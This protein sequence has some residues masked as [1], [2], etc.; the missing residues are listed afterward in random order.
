MSV[1]LNE[2]LEPAL[3]VGS[4]VGQF[5]PV[6]IGTLIAATRPPFDLYL[7]HGLRAQHVLFSERSAPLTVEA[8]ARLADSGVQALYISY[9]DRDAYDR[10]LHDALLENEELTLAQRYRLTIAAS[11]TVFEAAYTQ[12][13]LGAVVQVVEQVGGHISQRLL[14][15]D[16]V[17]NQLFDLMF[18]D[19]ST[20]THANNVCIY[21]V[22]LARA[23]GISNLNELAAIATGALLHDIGKRSIPP[24]ILNQAHHLTDA[25]KRIVR[26]H[27][28]LGYEDL[29]HEERLSWGQLM[30]VY[31]HHERLNGSGYPVRIHGDE[32]HPWAKLC[33]VADVFDALTSDRPFR[34]ALRVEEALRHLRAREG[35]EFDSEIVECLIALMMSTT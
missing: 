2:V 8:L 33:A 34:R 6:A 14:S 19:Y 32:M 24:L 26:R 29:C 12:N 30:M 15:Q 10:Y 3:R 20:F 31:Q 4:R 23:T 13:D 21:S 11:K 7:K 17:M 9:E 5:M 28:Q 1:G 35:T 25:Q 22:A 16:V 18:H 27:P